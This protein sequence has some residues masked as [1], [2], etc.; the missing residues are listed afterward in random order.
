M[1]MLGTIL[2]N[3]RG[4]DA[5]RQWTPAELRARLRSGELHEAA[6]DR[7]SD[8]TPQR[9]VAILCL[10]GELAFFQRKDADAEQLFRKALTIAP[11]SPDAYHGLS[12]VLQA[13][14]QTMEA[15]RHAQFAATNG[16]KEARF[17]AQLGLC[18][19]ELQNYVQAGQALELATRL[20]PEDKF[21]WNN[22]GIAMRANGELDRARVGFQ[23]ALK[24]DA[25]FGLAADN[26]AR[27]DQDLKTARAPLREAAAP[28][29]AEIANIRELAQMGD[30]AAAIDACERLSAEQPDDPFVVI[31][32]HRLYEVGGDAQ[33]GI[34]VLRAFHARHPDDTDVIATLGA[35]LVWAQEFDAAKPL[36]TDALARRPDEPR[37]IVAMS[38]IR[39]Q[40]GRYAESAQLLR[41]AYELDPTLERKGMLANSLVK[42][43]KYEEAVRLFDEIVAE[44]P[45]LAGMLEGVRIYSLMYL[46]RQDE[47]LPIVDEAIRQN[48]NEPMRRFPRA[49]IHLHNERYGQGWDDYAY[50]Q[51]ASAPHLRMLP[52]PEWRGEPLKDRSVLVLAEQGLGDQIM[53]AS[54]LP[55]LLKLRPGR[56]VVEAMDRVAPTLARS[57]PACEIVATQ[58]DVEFDWLHALGSFDFHVHMGD[59]PRVFRRE[60][61]HFPEHRGYLRPDRGRVA[62]WKDTL[63]AAGRPGKPRIGISWRGGT[64]MT[65]QGLRTMDVAML[66]PLMKGA[67]ASWVALQYGDIAAELKK[68]AD[69]GAP[70]LHWPEA[71]RDLDEFSALVSALDLVVTVCNTTVHYAGAVGKPVWVMAPKVP[72]WR[73]GL[74][75]DVMPWYPSSRMFRQLEHG[76]WERLLDKV[77]GELATWRERWEGNLSA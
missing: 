24:L 27:L 13:R 4:A 18:Q 32:L 7:L 40:Q 54:C 43:F 75:F 76:D 69:A 11:G 56:V 36:V 60:R 63:D 3:L 47:A 71:I 51:L 73:Y 58:Q 35:A 45:A 62:H 14:G 77:R 1:G 38:E 26:L 28:T 48:P 59:L 74:R 22:Y 61:A 53:F 21:S 39:S 37:L 57:F 42:I 15:V 46:G 41:R 72:E 29:S 34:D 23:R 25:G 2:R 6:I 5:K 9:E 8:T 12:L 66:A 67:D 64:E 65:R 55:D 44:D 68:S 31:E 10:R 19:V 30:V 50:R 16:G 20:D 70:L 49:T 17:W 52:F 33:S